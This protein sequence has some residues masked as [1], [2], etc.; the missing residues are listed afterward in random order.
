MDTKN[1]D[2]IPKKAARKRRGNK[3]TIDKNIDDDKPAPLT[4]EQLREKL[5]NKLRSKQTARLPRQAREIMIEKL[6][7]KMKGSSGKEKLQIKKQIK[8][9]IDIDEKEMNN[10]GERTIPEYDG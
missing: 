10:E 5:K 8:E 9:L 4:K 3:N 1:V 6:E 2:K 7:S